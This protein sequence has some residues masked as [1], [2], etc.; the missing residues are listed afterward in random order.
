M[1]FAFDTADAANPANRRAD[2]GD[3]PAPHDH[4]PHACRDRFADDSQRFAKDSHAENRMDKGDSRDSRDSHSFP[5]AHTTEDVAELDRLIVRLAELEAPW[6]AGYLPGLLDARRRMAPIHVAE[7]LANFR[8][9]VAEAE[10]R[11]TSTH[12]KESA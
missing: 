2:Q 5:A 3:A 12:R 1:K 8:R 10:V 7:N 9:W 11:T 4:A 6:L